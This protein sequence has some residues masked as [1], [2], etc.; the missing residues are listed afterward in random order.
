MA[1]KKRPA[2]NTTTR[3]L[4]S[5]DSKSSQDC[6]WHALESGEWE[7]VKN[8]DFDFHSTHFSLGTPFTAFLV[9]YLTLQGA[10]GLPSLKLSSDGDDADD[11]DWDEPARS[12]ALSLVTWL[13]AN[14][15]DPTA[16][17]PKSSEPISFEWEDP[18]YRELEVDIAGKSAVTVY[19]DIR[20]A[21]Q[22]QCLDDEHE[23]YEQVVTRMNALIEHMRKTP[24][25]S[26]QKKLSVPEV[27]VET[28]ERIF[29]LAAAEG[30]VCLISAD[31]RIKAHAWILQ[32]SSPVVKAMLQSGMKESSGQAE[33]IEIKVDEPPT[34]VRAFL[35]MLYT[36]QLTST[37]ENV[38]DVAALLQVINLCHR[39][40]VVGFMP[41]LESRACRLVNSDNVEAML[42]VAALCNLTILRQACFRVAQ[43]DT[44]L[45]DN[46][47]SGR[48]CSVVATELE[49]CFGTSSKRAKRQRTIV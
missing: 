12:L 37:G 43:V 36:G 1:P 3:K 19:I 20:D 44:A 29:T 40:Q 46:F 5:N 39:W 27:L 2:A 47:E 42:E 38:L 22:E 14:G 45:R 26:V 8:A 25:G 10:F 9:N 17:A 21:A 35:R 32:E 24:L 49:L 31:Q 4:R 28:W 34:A 41:H 11:E 18:E 6:M 30:D 33:I 15:S 13:L 7:I 48:C 16:V 23:R